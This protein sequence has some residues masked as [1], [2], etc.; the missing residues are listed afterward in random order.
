MLLWRKNNKPKNKVGCYNSTPIKLEKYESLKQIH[1]RRNY[2]FK[3]VSIICKFE[4]RLKLVLS[5]KT[6]R[7]PASFLVHDSPTCKF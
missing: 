2:P 1:N 3:L 5:D 4:S 7:H 6:R